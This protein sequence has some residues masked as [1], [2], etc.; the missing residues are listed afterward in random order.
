MFFLFW[1]RVGL[2]ELLG[3]DLLARFT[4]DLADVFDNG[5]FF[6]HGAAEFADGLPDFRAEHS[7]IPGSCCEHGD[8]NEMILDAVSTVE[9]RQLGF[10]DNPF[11]IAVIPVFLSGV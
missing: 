6:G 4:F 9:T 7:A 2:A 5:Q 1:G 3:R 8:V 11:E 10:L